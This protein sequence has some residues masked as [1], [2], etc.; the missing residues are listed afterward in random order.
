MWEKIKLDV[1][2]DL[3]LIYKQTKIGHLIITG[4]SLG[5]GLAAISYI[6]IEH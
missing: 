4:I 2:S 6:D 1:I 3:A 5:G